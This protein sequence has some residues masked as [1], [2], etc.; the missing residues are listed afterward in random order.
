[1]ANAGNDGYYDGLVDGDGN[2][3]DY[4]QLLV[5]KGLARRTGDG[6]ILINGGL[7]KT[8]SANNPS[9][10]DS[11]G[12]GAP[13]TGATGAPLTGG[14][15]QA[16]T[17]NSPYNPGD[18]I[19]GND[20]RMGIYAR[21]ID[22]TTGQYT[23]GFM[24]FPQ[25]GT[26]EF[27]ANGGWAT[28]EQ[29][30]G[31]QAT[32]L[33]AAYQTA[34]NNYAQSKAGATKLGNYTVEGINANGDV[35]AM[36]GD[37]TTVTI[38]AADVAAGKYPGITDSDL[39]QAKAQYINSQRTITLAGKYTV[40][41]INDDGSVN[42]DKGDG[43]S[44]T[45]SEADA[46]SGKYPGITPA[47]IRAAK[48]QFENQT[49]TLNESKQFQVKSANADGTITLQKGDGTLVTVSAADA[50]GGKYPGIT[51]TAIDQAK[52]EQVQGAWGQD[53]AF[54][55][56]FAQQQGLPGGSNTAPAPAPPPPPNS[57]PPAATPP[58]PI[59]TS[60]AAP[61]P[62][63]GALGAVPPNALPMGAGAGAF[64]VTGAPQ[65]L[66]G[67]SA[68]AG[69]AGQGGFASYGPP[70]QATQ[71]TQATLTGQGT[72]AP[73]PQGAPPQGAPPPSAPPAA[74]PPTAMPT[75]LP[76]ASPPGNAGSS[77]YT[78]G[79]A[80][81]SGGSTAPSPL[82]QANPSAKP[83]PSFSAQQQA[84][85]AAVPLPKAAPTG[86]AST[87]SS[88]A[89]TATTPPVSAPPA[90][91]QPYTGGVTGINAAAAQ[92]GMTN[93]QLDLRNRTYQ[94]LSNYVRAG[95]VGSRNLSG[96]GSSALG[97]PLIAGQ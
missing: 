81:L 60:A 14:N 50:I 53:N 48:A 82:P 71:A 63:A 93:Q 23:Y 4:G 55:P 34:K 31:I 46:A 67:G 85:W 35:I 2:L 52:S 8:G 65:G 28:V 44:A 77:A 26:P 76:Q 24:Y 16:A 90:M 68:V 38:T 91:P 13:P 5:S 7:P 25:P 58:N 18:V 96:M 36:K 37:G 84:Q 27:D 74:P 97:R 1:M 39:A 61:P 80:N 32:F 41:G 9:G 73:P 89:A 11:S 92:Q 57:V 79:S 17:G 78:L 49:K 42:V 10:P 56:Q 83:A 22:R 33:D 19:I 29:Q 87:A 72:I 45:I 3:T 59:P 51:Q 12:A 86:A 88:G 69:V 30:T 62:S 6:A 94:N 70:A 40:T 64:G 95:N 47:D 15:A 66:P 20:G 54:G 43:T 75:P 21:Q